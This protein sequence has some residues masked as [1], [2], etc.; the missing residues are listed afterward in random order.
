M[1][2]GY[3]PKEPL[4]MSGIVLEN[5]QGLFSLNAATPLSLWDSNYCGVFKIKSHFRRGIGGFGDLLTVV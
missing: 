5:F 1:G 4:E 2:R 3:V